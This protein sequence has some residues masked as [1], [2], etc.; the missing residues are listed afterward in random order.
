[1][2]SS[3]ESVEWAFGRI[4]MLWPFVVYKIKQRIL[5]SPVGV[6]MK[7][8]V[9]FTNINTCYVEGNLISDYFDCNPQ[10]FVSI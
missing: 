8:A 4:K 6:I 9:L 5:L 2:S 7:L 3:R 10:V 1:M